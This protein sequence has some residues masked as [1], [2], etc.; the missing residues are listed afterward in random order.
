M[1]SRFH[2]SPPWPPLCIDIS[3]DAQ[4]PPPKVE[5]IRVPAGLHA[6]VGF[7]ES[8]ATGIEQ[9]TLWFHRQIGA[10]FTVIVVGVFID[11]A[12]VVE[13]REQL[14]HRR[15]RPGGRSNHQPVVA[16]ARPVRGT[17]IAVPVDGKV[18]PQVF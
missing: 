1:V 6:D 17:V 2:N 15:V 3:D 7:S 4:Y 10:A 8:V 9:A 12:R 16:H 13:K 11:A 5:T 18:L 14:H